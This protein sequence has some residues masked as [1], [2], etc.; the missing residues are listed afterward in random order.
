MKITL[1]IATLTVLFFSAFLWLPSIS[2]KSMDIKTFDITQQTNNYKHQFQPYNE[3]PRNDYASFWK[4]PL[5]NKNILSKANPEIMRSFDKEFITE[6]VIAKKINGST[7][8][9]SMKVALNDKIEVEIGPN[10]TKKYN[11]DEMTIEHAASVIDDI[12]IYSIDKNGYRVGPIENISFQIDTSKQK[13]KITVDHD[14]QNV[15]TTV[16]LPP[17][18]Y[19]A[20]L[21]YNYSVI[22]EEFERP[23]IT[24]TSIDFPIFLEEK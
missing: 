4:R 23:M 21:Q 5:E 2:L 7:I 14:L 19:V 11:I 22:A 3:L 6:Y 1:S 10:K 8:G 15:I 13:T 17:G 16:E 24:A 9:F 18:K 20:V 12:K